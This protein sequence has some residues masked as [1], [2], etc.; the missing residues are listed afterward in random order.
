VAGA[1]LIEDQANR[2]EIGL[3]RDLRAAQL[4][5]GH[6]R[7]RSNNLA[8]RGK[9][10][11]GLVRASRD[12]EVAQHCASA[13]QKNVCRLDVAVDDALCVCRRERAEQVSSQCVHLGQ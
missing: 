10:V 9:R 5:R 8:W 1:R 11:T 4:L 12:A 7:Q 3:R 6:I 2:V 13:E